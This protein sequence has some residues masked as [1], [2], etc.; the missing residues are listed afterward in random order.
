MLSLSSLESWS[1]MRPIEWREVSHPVCHTE[2][3]L[4][5][6][7]RAKPGLGKPDA[8][9]FWMVWIQVLLPFAS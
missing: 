6:V 5:N 9:T 1:L 7:V 3:I 8:E 4:R 2:R